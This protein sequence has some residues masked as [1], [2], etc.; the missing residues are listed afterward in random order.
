MSRPSWRAVIVGSGAAVLMLA[1]LVAWAIRARAPYR[2]DA[3]LVSGW[4][5]AAAPPADAAVVELKPPPQLLEDLFEQVSRRTNGPLVAAPRAS[6]PLVLAGEY[7]DSLQG[8]LSIEDIVSVGQAVGL[9]RMRFEPVCV[10]Q[11]RSTGED[12]GEL[13]F[14]IFDAPAFDE[15]RYELTPLFPEHAGAGVYNPPALRLILPIAATDQNFA[16]FWPMAVDAR[17]D[18]RTPLRYR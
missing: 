2:V 16:R 17:S 5:L 3:A 4:T 10:G 13:Y 7:S 6:V 18:C 12:A 9:D 14:A 1:V 11:R 8:V 15:F